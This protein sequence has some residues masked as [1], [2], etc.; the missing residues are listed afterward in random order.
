MH[1]SPTLLLV[2]F[3]LFFVFRF[4]IIYHVYFIALVSHHLKVIFFSV[5]FL[6]TFL[7]SLSSIFF[8]FHF[9]F[10]LLRLL[11]NLLSMN[12]RIFSK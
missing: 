3:S 8:F 6:F 1:A 12:D 2:L 7:I 5:I 9:N 11:I 10:L 4:K